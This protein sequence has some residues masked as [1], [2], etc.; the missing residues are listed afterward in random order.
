MEPARGLGEN[1]FAIAGGEPAAL[2]VPAEH[3]PDAR[4]PRPGGGGTPPERG[5]GRPRRRPRREEPLRFEAESRPRV[6]PWPRAAA[7]PGHG[8]DVS[9]KSL[10]PSCRQAAMGD[11][12]PLEGEGKVTAPI[13]PLEVECRVCRAQ[14]YRDPIAKVES[15]RPAS[16]PLHAYRAD[17]LLRRHLL[18]LVERRR[19]HR[20]PMV[21][22]GVS[23]VCGRGVANL[24]RNS[25]GE[26]CCCRQTGTA[27]GT[28]S[29][30]QLAVEEDRNWHRQPT[31]SATH[32]RVPSTPGRQ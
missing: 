3:R 24:P 30:R 11:P 20:D 18:G 13:A 26:V 21:P 31:P 8:V 4:W 19:T 12:Q 27:L 16:G 10:R 23:H 6:A 9:S 5:D 15:P 29:R 28:G 7:G 22:G 32:P 2:A 25:V 1:G 17:R 14:R